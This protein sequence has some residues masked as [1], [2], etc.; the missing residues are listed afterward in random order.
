M[1]NK[2]L[3]RF[4]R[5]SFVCLSCTSLIIFVFALSACG[6]AGNA[7]NSHNSTGVGGTTHAAIPTIY[8]K[9]SNESS[10]GGTG[11]TYTCSPNAL[12]IHMGEHVTFVNQS[13]QT[14]DFD[15]GDAQQ[16]NIDFVMQPNQSM[17]IVFATAGTF[18][19]ASEAGASFTITVH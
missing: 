13:G 2:L 4:S 3:T 1:R 19:I 8:V 5:Q 18:K 12:T 9:A 7:G 11:A 17:N 6:N 15:Q 14:Q 10:F 16:A